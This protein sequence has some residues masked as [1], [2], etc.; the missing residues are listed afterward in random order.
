[1]ATSERRQRRDFLKRSLAVGGGL[2][3]A[4]CW[5]SLPASGSDSPNEKLNL[6]AIGTAARAAADIAGCQTENIVALC[7]VDANSLDKAAGTYQQ[8]RKYVDFRVMLEKEADRIDG[9]IIGTPDHTHAPAASMAL[10][11]GKPVYCEKPLTHTV[12]EARRLAQLA[13]ENGCV[14]QMGNQIHSGD[15][16]RRVVEIVESGTIGPVRE[17]HVWVGVDYAG[18]TLLT[19]KPKPAHVNWD[20]WLGPAPKRPYVEANIRGKHETVHPFH[21]RW[22]WDYGTGGFGDFGCHYM[23]LAHWALHLRYPTSIQASGPAVDP[24]ATTAGLV[25]EYEYPAREELPPV[26]L[27]WY[28]GGKRPAILASLKDRSGNPL[29][30]KSGQLFIGEK[31]MVLSN[32]GNHVLIP[33]DPDDELL[34]P[35]P[36]IPK[37]LG[38]HQEWIHAIKTSGPTTCNFDYAGALTE[39]V[40]LGVVAYRSG[41]TLQWDG[42]NFQLQNSAAAQHLLH[43]EYRDGWTI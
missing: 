27:T 29:D 39:A 19:D 31:G 17:A 10:Q 18:G 24:V 6:A 9:V 37:S 2:M 12:Y 8:A 35:E 34:P 7:D 28:D 26:R 43:K 38:Q 3:T 36:Y 42:D 15:N 4:G 33:N 30:W 32:Y 11:M 23:D 40:M 16:Y 14:T 5:S 25:V 21:W 20:L 1:M 22:F 13:A 41:E